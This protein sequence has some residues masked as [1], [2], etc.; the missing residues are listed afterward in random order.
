MALGCNLIA[1]TVPAN[2]I[3][4]LSGLTPGR[5][6][7]GR[8]HV[9]VGSDISLAQDTVDASGHVSFVKPNVDYLSIDYID[10]ATGQIFE[11]V[12]TSDGSLLNPQLN[13]GGQVP[14]F[15]G[16]GGGRVDSFFDIYIE[17]DW[18][19]YHA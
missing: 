8:V 5:L 11:T 12:T 15:A 7:A 16:G 18:D 6:I 10:V 14:I 1:A 2:T 17:L 3:D 19:F 4:T 9:A 13:A